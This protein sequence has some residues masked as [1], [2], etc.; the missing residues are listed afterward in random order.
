MN[1]EWKTIDTAP[2][3]GTEILGYRE[4][5]GVLLIRWC[6][7]EDFFTDQELEC[8]NFTDEEIQEQDWFFADFSQ[9]DRLSSSGDATHWM[10]LPEPPKQ[11]RR[12]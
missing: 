4:D 1:N 2:Q 12:S 5:C 9:G 10:P 8:T 7:L 3:D 6:A 11:N